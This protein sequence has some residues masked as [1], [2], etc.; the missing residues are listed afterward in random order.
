MRE[1]ERLRISEAKV[2]GLE[3]EVCPVCHEL[4]GE[5]MRVGRC[6]VPWE[7][8]PP[9]VLTRAYFLFSLG[10]PPARGLRDK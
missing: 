2:L 6:E 4:S 7:W 8:V 9:R 5:C 10:A 3:A 1:D